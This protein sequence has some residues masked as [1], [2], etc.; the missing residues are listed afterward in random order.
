VGA[1]QVTDVSHV[2]AMAEA[3]RTYT[4]QASLGKESEQVA[5]EL[6]LRAERRRGEL[7]AQG[8]EAGEIK[9]TTGRP[10]KSSS[11]LRISKAQ[12]MRLGRRPVQGSDEVRGRILAARG[13]GATFAA[14]AAELNADGVPT[15]QGGS[16]WYPGTVRYVVVGNERGQEVAA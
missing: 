14:I 10:E 9:A 16:K 8:Q 15:A 1:N 6:R 2:V 5:C 4:V 13:A 11:T 3:I 7:I 12:G